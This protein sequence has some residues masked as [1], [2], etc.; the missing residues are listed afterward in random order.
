MA[1]L[2][3][4]V[5]PFWAWR[6]SPATNSSTMPSAFEGIMIPIQGNRESFE[7]PPGN[8]TSLSRHCTDDFAGGILLST[9]ETDTPLTRHCL[10]RADQLIAFANLDL[11][12]KIVTRTQFS[13]SKRNRP[14]HPNG[15]P[16]AG[17]ASFN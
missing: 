4:P 12:Q 15:S 8:D 10:R 14:T 3:Q 1:V 9:Q 7:H 5:E 2:L 16:I 17:F 6:L 11:K 13:F